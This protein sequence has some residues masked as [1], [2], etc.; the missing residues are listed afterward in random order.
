[1]SD[2]NNRTK[3]TFLTV[4]QFKAR[5]N[6]T[7]VEA[8]IV[9]NPH[10]G[11]LFLAVGDLRFKVQANIDKTKNMSVLVPEDGGIEQACLINANAPTENVMFTI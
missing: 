4:E 2:L 9:K 11:K 5:I 6:K 7:G 3:A 10:T 8:Q 1:M